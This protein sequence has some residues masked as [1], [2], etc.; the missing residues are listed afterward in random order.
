[1]SKKTGGKMERLQYDNHVFE[2]GA[3]RTYRKFINYSLPALLLGAAE[4][5]LL[6]SG[7]MSNLGDYPVVLQWIFMLITV[8]YV[9]PGIFIMPTAWF[10]RSGKTRLLRESYILAGSR[11]IEF[12][13]V[14]SK[15]TA[16]IRE[17]VY[18]CTQIKKVEEE[19]KCYVVTGHV[20]EKNTGN[21]SSELEIPKAFSDMDKIEKAARYK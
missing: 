21:E 1:M 5:G 4:I 19:K 16:G 10:L 6:N 8:I 17:N 9:I 11:Y 18:V 3:G 20:T 12:H 14:V 7:V 15:S 2:E 13:K